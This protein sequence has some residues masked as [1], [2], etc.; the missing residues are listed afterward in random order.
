M[1]AP[2]DL[3]QFNCIPISRAC[4]ACRAWGRHD[5]R[6][7]LHAARLAYQA[8]CA[9]CGHTWPC[10]ITA[11]DRLALQKELRAFS[12]PPLCEECARYR[13]DPPSRLCPGCEAYREHQR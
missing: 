4:P 9:R 2:D 11:G 7:L 6:P 5:T 3:I 8:T 12:K 13:A 1:I 10:R